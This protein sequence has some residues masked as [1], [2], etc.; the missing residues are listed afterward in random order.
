MRRYL[1]SIITLVLGLVIVSIAFV[2]SRPQ[3]RA[4]NGGLAAGCLSAS[5]YVTGDG[6]VTPNG[7]PTRVEGSGVFVRPNMVLTAKHVP[8]GLTN[9][10]VLDYTMKWHGVTEVIYD[11]NDDMALL[12]LDSPGP[13]YVTIG[14]PPDL[15]SQLFAIGAPNGLENYPTITTGV[16]SKEKSKV[17]PWWTSVVTCDVL[18]YPGSSGGGMFYNNKLVGIVVGMYV[19]RPQMSMYEPIA[20]LD[21]N[22]LDIIYPASN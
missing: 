7:D 14:P 22:I 3:K 1:S 9:L 12:I 19:Y 11:V 16:K 21:Q 18:V 10:R 15:G 6:P 2:G 8:E 13:G 5:A 20:D 4:E 17:P